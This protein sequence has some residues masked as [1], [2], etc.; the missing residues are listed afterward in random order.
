LQ[1]RPRAG[2][3]AQTLRRRFSVRLSTIIERYEALA[4]IPPGCRSPLDFFLLEKAFYEI[5]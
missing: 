3:L 2:G 4:A 5:E 1:D